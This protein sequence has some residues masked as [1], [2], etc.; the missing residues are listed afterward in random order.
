M[1]SLKIMMILMRRNGFDD[2]EGDDD[3]DAE[4][5]DDDQPDDNLSTLSHEEPSIATSNK[6]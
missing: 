6:G 2:N 5:D 1:Y 4:D 3:N